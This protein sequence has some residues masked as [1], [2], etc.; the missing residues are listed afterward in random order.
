LE[1]DLRREG[2]YDKPVAPIDTLDRQYVKTW[3]ARTLARL[4]R[5]DPANFRQQMSTNSSFFTP[6]GWLG[7]VGALQE[8]GHLRLLENGLASFAAEPSA[9]PIIANE[10]SA[11]GARIWEL[12]IPM[13]FA[14][15]FGIE[16]QSMRMMARVVVMRREAQ[17]EV[18]SFAL[19]SVVISENR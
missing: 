9:Q 13:N 4:F 11:D 16:Q 1:R 19:L 17:F 5:L 18:G 2:V 8:S 15:N 6:E 3:S 12:D 14:A 10:F 7:F